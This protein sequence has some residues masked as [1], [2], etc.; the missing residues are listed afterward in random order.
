MQGLTDPDKDS[1]FILNAME[2]IG[3]HKLSC[4]F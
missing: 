1:G 3:G 4:I 2:N